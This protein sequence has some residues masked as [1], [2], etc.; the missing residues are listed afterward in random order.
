[1]PIFLILSFFLKLG[2]LAIQH[3]RVSALSAPSFYRLSHPFS[4][5][6]K[7]CSSAIEEIVIRQPLV[8]V[9]PFEYPNTQTDRENSYG[10]L[11]ICY[12][13]VELFEFEFF[14]IDGIWGPEGGVLRKRIK[15]FQL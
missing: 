12:Y 6:D 8:V 11:F 3:L 2:Y 14:K 9:T 1:M 15:N 13:M 10:T 5:V 4:V 7:R